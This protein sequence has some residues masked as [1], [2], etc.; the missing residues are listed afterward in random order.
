MHEWELDTGWQNKPRV[1]NFW[2][3]AQSES[4]LRAY[5]ERGLSDPHTIPAIVEMDGRSVGYFE[6]YWVREDRLGPIYDCSD[7]DRG[8]HFLIGEDD[9]LGFKNTDAVLKSTSHFI[10]LDDVRTQIIAAEPR[11]DNAAVLKYVETFKCWRKV[12]EFDFPHK[13]AALLEARR[14]LFM[15]EGYPWH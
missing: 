12:R 1:A 4:E 2:E 15:R 6:F 9:C 14:D 8:F 7:Y 13:R 3:I 10:F 5:L 11:A